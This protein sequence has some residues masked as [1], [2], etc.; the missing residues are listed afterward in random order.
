[1]DSKDFEILKCLRS[2]SRVSMGAIAEKLGISKAT[3]SRRLSRMEK[4]GIITGY[5]VDINPSK[6]GLMRALLSI[7]VIGSSVN[8]VIAEIRVFPEV[9][10]IYKSFGDQNIVVELLT[11]S[12]DSLYE[13]IQDKFLSIPNI[14]NVEVDILVEKIE[15]DPNSDIK[16]YY[17]DL[18]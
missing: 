11:S 14:Y 4:E 9:S 5:S 17:R 10:A 8:T 2:D 1:M 16:M 13:L 12:V 6:L 3:V 7:E 18:H 15:I